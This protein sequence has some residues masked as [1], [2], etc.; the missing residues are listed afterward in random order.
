M[1]TTA[2]MGAASI[3]SS[4][5]LTSVGL[6]EAV[7][8]IGMVAMMFPAMIPVVLLYNKVATK[9][10]SNP[11]LARFIG[12]SL[13]LLGYLTIYA[14]LGLG[15]YFAVYG[16]INLSMAAPQVNFLAHLAP[17]LVLLFAGVYQLT[18]LK[19]QCLS[20]CV[21]PMGFFVSHG[22][23]GLSG[24]VQMGLSHGYYCA[25]CCWLFMLVMLA[26]GAMSLP[27]MV[28]LSAVIVLEKVI[29]KGS[30]WFTRAVAGGFALLGIFAIFSPTILNL[31]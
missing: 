1:T 17:G 12:T 6:F 28:I 25:G 24:S 4:L 8:V 14:L 11:R 27:S 16:A 19:N 13:F 26:V 21:S 15:A 9:V 22:K 23:R 31:V 30:A 2:E 7:W 3:V 29:V 10:E 18:P 20:R 5:T